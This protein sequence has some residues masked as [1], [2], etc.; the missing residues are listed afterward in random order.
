MRFQLANVRVTNERKE[1]WISSTRRCLSSTGC[2]RH[3]R[4]PSACSGTHRGGLHLLGARGYAPPAPELAHRPHDAH[5]HDV[6]IALSDLQF[7]V[8]EQQLDLT[9]VEA[10]LEP[11]TG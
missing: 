11:A 1:P 10:V 4:R 2:R 6:Q 9:D 3:G 7:G 5:G 8:P